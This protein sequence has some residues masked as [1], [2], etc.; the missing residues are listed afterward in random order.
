[1]PDETRNRDHM[2]PDGDPGGGDER[3]HRLVRELRREPRVRPEA[4][5]AVMAEVLASPVV[6]PGGAVA[7][8]RPRR[9]VLG[10]L[11]RPRT[12]AV[13]PLHAAAALLLVA[14]ALGAALARD[15]AGGATS[16]ETVAA[17]TTGAPAAVSPASSAGES[18]TVQFVF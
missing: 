10:W 15:G 5:D 12:I 7:A 13:T 11:V 4:L 1:M 16:R 2:D 17:T 3:W 18:R 6:V 14:V 8:A 9:D